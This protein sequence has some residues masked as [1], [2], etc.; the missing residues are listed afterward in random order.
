MY[1]RSIDNKNKKEFFAKLTEHWLP[2]IKQYEK[3]T[4][5]EGENEVWEQIQKGIRANKQRK[6]RHIVYFIISSAA[7]V[8][9]LFGGI[10]ALINEAG[11]NKETIELANIPIP[12]GVKDEITL[13]TSSHKNLNVE[14]NS[15][16]TYDKDGSVTVNSRKISP[17]KSGKT[18]NEE[19]AY[20]QIIVPPG[21]RTNVFFADGTR[22]YVNA[23]TRVVYPT[24]FAK[25]KRE[26]YVDGE[27]FLE[28]KKDISRPFIVKTDNMNVRVLGTS[29]NVCSYKQDKESSVVLVSGKV[30][31][32]TKSKQKV[33][34]S[35]D[36]M[37]KLNASEFSTRKVDVYNYIS[38]KDGV[39]KLD[40]EPLDKVLI[41]LSRYYGQE[42]LFDKSLASMPI[43]GKLDLRDNLDEVIDIIAETAP[44]T[45]IQKYNTIY[46]KGEK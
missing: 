37:F 1:K 24:V 21:K 3:T 9:L 22:I 7:C 6:N 44:I 10:Y 4:Y 31:V 17:A 11:S 16:V 42:I 26:I 30:E 39:M 29:F 41:K 33:Y 36:D 25:D 46:V 28:V 38:W 20:N 34:L 23:G 18:K 27:I 8:L 35:P 14:D 32:Q 19:I 5:C 43:S 45:V 12:D 13:V 40:A 15:N 2:S